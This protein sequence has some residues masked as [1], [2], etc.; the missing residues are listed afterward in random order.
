MRAKLLRKVHYIVKS[1]V[2][3]V[4][5]VLGTLVGDSAS[6]CGVSLSGPDDRRRL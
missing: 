5:V 4:T 6:L 3:Y 2:K 1:N